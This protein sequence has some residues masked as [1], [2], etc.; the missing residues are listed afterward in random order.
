[1]IEVLISLVLTGLIGGVVVAVI[2]TSLN[3][4]DSTTAEINDSNDAALVSSFL[5]R[6]G[7]SS[8]G[9]DPTTATATA[10]VSTTDAAGCAPAGAL[11]VRFSW[12]EHTSAS[13]HTPTVVTYAFDSVAQTLTRRICKDGSATGTDVLLGSHVKSATATCQRGVQV[14][15]TCS[16]PTAVSLA[17]TGSGIRAPYSTTLTASLRSATSQLMIVNPTSTSL[18]A[19]EVGVAY[20]STRLTT[21]GATAPTSWSQTTGLPAGLSI[22]GNGVIAGT[23]T[24]AGQ[25][26]VNATI[27]DK[28]AATARRTYSVAISAPLAVVW[29]SLPN[30]KVGVAYSATPGS[31]SGGTLPYVWT[32]TGLPAGL[33]FDSATGKIAGTPTL[34]GTS[35]LTIT[36]TDSLGAAA[37]KSY[38]L[39]VDPSNVCVAPTPTTWHGEYFANNSVSGTPTMTR[40][41]ADINF[42]WGTSSPGPGIPN[43]NFSIRWTKTPNL[44]PGTYTFTLDADAGARLFIDD[45]A[46]IDN[47]N[48]VKSST[49]TR[50]L[51]GWHALRVEY[52]DKNGNARALLTT[53]FAAVAPVDNNGVSATSAVPNS[54]GWFGESNILL[55]TTDT[56]TDMSATIMVAQTPGVTYHGQWQNIQKDDVVEGTATSC[57]FIFYTFTLKQTKT[58]GTG[59]W[60]L[61]AQW[62][63]TGTIHPTSGDTWTLTVRTSKGVKTFSGTF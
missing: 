29:S 32:Q 23:P 57:G 14:D 4:A 45:V 48:G 61:A 42:V 13:S 47:W 11:V 43:D 49:V 27:A 40:E 26:T 50:F 54:Q 38:S 41:D 30:G 16:R 18:P 58:I 34:A 12:I 17:L 15:T 5:I 46:V 21:I 37:Q 59:S 36:V 3:A 9:I 31:A 25:F 6:D 60:V 20:R 35:A 53:T 19:G 55:N 56:I 2:L 7:Q 63:G 8:G 39:V 1:M 52:R 10:G 33:T 22:D 62:D 51:T 44:D 28:W 24:V